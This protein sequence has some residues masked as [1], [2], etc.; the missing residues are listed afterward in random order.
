M[1]RLHFLMPRKSRELGK[2]CSARSIAHHQV[3]RPER[4]AAD[5]QCRRGSGPGSGESGDNND[6]TLMVTVKDE[7]GHTL[8]SL[9]FFPGY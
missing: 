1:L 3:G 2:R 4:A 8:L 5:Y 6:P 7:T 9:P